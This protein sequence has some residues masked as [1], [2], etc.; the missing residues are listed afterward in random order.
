MYAGLF[1]FTALMVYGVS[2][3]MDSSLPAWSQRQAP[4]A[5]E[6][7]VAFDIPGGLSDKEVADVVYAYLDMPLTGP[8]QDYSMRRDAEHHLVLSFYTVNG[9]R[10]VTVLE[11]E[12]QLKV[13]TAQGGMVSFVTGMHGSRMM[14]ASPRFLT[15]AW[16]VYNEAGLWSLGFMAL[17]GTILWLSTRP[18]FVWAR[19]AFVA[20]NCAFIAV[21]WLMR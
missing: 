16:A 12:R 2:G 18:R 13:V 3:L 5:T 17:S 6:R 10:T 19:V 21:Y 1:T 20:G 7:N 11:A 4:P 8:A 14:Y 15:V 9:V